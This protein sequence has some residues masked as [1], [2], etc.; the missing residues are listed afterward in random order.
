MKRCRE[1]DWPILSQSVLEASLRSLPPEE[2]YG[3][4]GQLAREKW[5]ELY[6]KR[7]HEWTLRLLLDVATEIG[8]ELTFYLSQGISEMG[9]F[10]N[11]LHTIKEKRKPILPL[12]GTQTN[13]RTCSNWVSQLRRWPTNKLGHH[14]S[15][16]MQLQSESCKTWRGL[17]SRW[18]DSYL[19]PSQTK[20]P[21]K[22]KS[23]CDL[24]T[25]YTVLNHL[26]I[27]QETSS[28]IPQMSSWGVR[29]RLLWCN[30]AVFMLPVWS[31]F[32]VD[33]WARGL[34]F[35]AY[36]LSWHLVSLCN[37]VWPPPAK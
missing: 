15:R 7:T 8:S 29:V 10:N 25:L 1:K 23:S 28:R 19:P 33:P 34:G 32:L 4:V 31:V 18:I 12:S 22:K 13:S 35:C 30:C 5:Q 27:Q 9:C 2:Y 14:K 21:L 26:H 24:S 20:K 37:C 11:Y 3:R 16:Y 6:R 17:S 36:T